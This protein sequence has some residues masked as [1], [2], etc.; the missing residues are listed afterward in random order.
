MYCGRRK[1]KGGVVRGRFEDEG[2]EREQ[3]YPVDERA[4]ALVDLH[5]GTGGELMGG[6]EP[7]RKGRVREDVLA[8][9]ERLAERRREVRD[10]LLSAP[11]AAVHRR[12]VLVVDV[13]TVEAVGLDPL[14]HGVRG[15][16]RVHA[17]GG[18]GVG[19][20][21]GG[22]DDL[23]AGLVV[24]V[25]LRGLGAGRERGPV[26]RLVDG[27]LAGEERERDDVVAL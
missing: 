6:G 27:T 2:G 13:D 12:E 7:G 19:R 17:R 11:G 10:P 9:G 24:L 16:D 26:A 18:G 4:D 5:V 1:C 23:D 14:G 8:L 20:A 21:E 25:L 3:A 22:R 15:G